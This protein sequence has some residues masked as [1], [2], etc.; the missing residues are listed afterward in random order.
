M[1][2]LANVRDVEHLLITIKENHFFQDEINDA[3]SRKI[4]QVNRLVAET[5]KE[6]V[7][8]QL[9][10]TKAIIREK[11][12][13]I[14]LKAA[15]ETLKALREGL[16]ET[17][18]AIPPAEMQVIRCKR[19]LVAAI[20]HREDMERRLEM[21]QRAVA[22][23]S[24][25]LEQLELDF[26]ATKARIE[27]VSAEGTIRIGHAYDILTMYLSAVGPEAR[28]DYEQWEKHEPE[29]DK[30]V[31][32]VDI[33]RRLNTS[34]NVMLGL[35]AYLYATDSN[36]YGFVE[37]RRNEFTQGILAQEE[38]ERKI[39]KNMVGR[40]AEEIVIRAFKPYATNISTQNITRFEDEHYT[41]TDLVV[42]NL[43]VPV[44]LGR[45]T[46]MGA[47]KGGSIAVEVKAG[48]PEYLRQQKEHLLFQAKGHTAYNASCTICTRDLHDLAAEQ[49]FRN[50]I[51]AG[52]SPLLAMLPYKR[53]LDAVCIDFVMGKGEK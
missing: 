6:E 8:T 12:A 39:R 3:C 45:G 29:K 5:R 15:E 21:A 48:A 46:G 28:H 51:R 34:Y 31:T 24:A 41:K 19:E 22:R 14:A 42:S 27:E 44:I 13:R 47:Q 50:E 53:D 16:P 1:D 30:P 49:E 20:K 10:L 23:A 17:A 33:S 37:M 35:L 26:R 40:L 18:A 4:Y 2:S 38:I 11:N 43:K 9:L 52:G 7:H 36:F 25:L 32:P